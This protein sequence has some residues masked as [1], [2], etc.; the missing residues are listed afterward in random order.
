M[1]EK[2][3]QMQTDIAL[4]SQAIQNHEGI[5]QA[6]VTDIKEIKE[7][8]LG[9]PS[10]PVLLIMSGLATLCGILITFILSKL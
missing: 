2:L 5:I 10:W 1:E 4:N 9:R 7:K 6:L 3:E 8:L